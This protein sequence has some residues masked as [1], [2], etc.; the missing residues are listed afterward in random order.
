LHITQLDGWSLGKSLVP[1][2]GYIKSLG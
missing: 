1:T 2:Q